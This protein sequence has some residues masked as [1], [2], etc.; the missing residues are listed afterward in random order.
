VRNTLRVTYT[1]ES[2]RASIE[3]IVMRRRTFLH[4]ASTRRAHAAPRIVT[5]RAAP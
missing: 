3:Q 2:K 4:M 1:P 5:S